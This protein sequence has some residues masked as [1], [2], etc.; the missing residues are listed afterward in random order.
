MPIDFGTYDLIIGKRGLR[1][2]NILISYELIENCETNVLTLTVTFL[3]NETLEAPNL[4]YHVLTAKIADVDGL[5][6]EIIETN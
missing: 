5:E 1:T 4:T 3:Q 2:G 6:V